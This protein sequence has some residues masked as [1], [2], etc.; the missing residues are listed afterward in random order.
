MKLTINTFTA[1]SYY[2]I[3]V[4]RLSECCCTKSSIKNKSLIGLITNRTAEWPGSFCANTGDVLDNY[5]YRVSG[6]TVREAV[7]F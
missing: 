7:N 6:N 4:V 5:W 3:K 1:V 2:D